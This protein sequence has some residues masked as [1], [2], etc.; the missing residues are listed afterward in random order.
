MLLAR[1]GEYQAD[2]FTKICGY[3]PHMVTALDKMYH[4]R[5]SNVSIL[6]KIDDIIRVIS[7]AIS[8]ILD[9]VLPIAVHPNLRRRKRELEKEDL[10]EMFILDEGAKDLAMKL[11]AKVLSPLDKFAAKHVDLLFPLAK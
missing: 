5:R 10:E 9:E 6:G 1:S 8:N 4:G 7:M 2:N 11:I 3:S